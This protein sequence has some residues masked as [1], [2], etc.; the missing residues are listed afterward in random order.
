[1]QVSREELLHIANLARLKLKDDEIENYLLNLQDILNFAEIVNNAPVNIGIHE[2]FWIS[3]F[4]VLGIY[5]LWGHMV[6]LLSVF[7][8]VSIMVSTVHQFMLPPTVYKDSPFST[9]SSTFVICVIFGDS[10]SDRCEVISLCDF[11]LHFHDD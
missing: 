5:P 3:V 11:D 1:M 4:E 10:H 9:S 6:V 2:F 8:E 7:W